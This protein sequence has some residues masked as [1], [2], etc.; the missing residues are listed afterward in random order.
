MLICLHPFHILIRLLKARGYA[1]KPHGK[2]NRILLYAEGNFTA[3]A[4][5]S[6]SLTLS[7][8]NNP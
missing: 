3:L 6:S 1:L 2:S 4:G 8:A 7:P 5:Y